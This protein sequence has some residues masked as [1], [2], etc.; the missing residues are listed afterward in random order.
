[1]RVARRSVVQSILSVS[2]LSKKR[3]ESQLA[4]LLF[5]SSSSSLVYLCFL[6]Y[7]RFRLLAV[8][9]A[10]HEFIPSVRQVA[11]LRESVLSVPAVSGRREKEGRLGSFSPLARSFRF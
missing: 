8:G 6:S 7:Y 3:K 11:L 10:A 5:S 2:G 4:K 1:M 9:K